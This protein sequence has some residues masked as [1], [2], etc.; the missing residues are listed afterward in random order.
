[1]D[2]FPPYF[3][4]DKKKVKILLTGTDPLLYTSLQRNNNLIGRD[5]KAFVNQG[6][7]YTAHKILVM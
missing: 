6:S 7:K 3:M 4:F 5:M 1:M 2:S